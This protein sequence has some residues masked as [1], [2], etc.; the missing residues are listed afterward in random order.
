MKESLQLN[1]VEYSKRALSDLESIWA[2][3]AVD[4]ETQANRLMIGFAKKF[5]S[6]LNSPRLGKMRNDL[7]VGL[8]SFPNGKYLIFYQE[9]VN[10]IEIVRVIHGAR[11]IEQVFEEMIPEK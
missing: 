2:Y 1:Q 7:I 6:L 10:G 4:S 8:R 11:D 9:T 3:I 5:R